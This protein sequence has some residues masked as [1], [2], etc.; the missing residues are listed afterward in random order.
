M[1]RRTVLAACS[2]IAF[3]VMAHA[4]ET[5]DLFLRAYQ[6]FQAGEKLERDGDALALHRGRLGVTL[7]FH[8]S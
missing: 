4:Q 2:L 3:A 6:E 8:R 7:C 1:L 5:S